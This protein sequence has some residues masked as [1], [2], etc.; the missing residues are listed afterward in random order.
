MEEQQQQ[1][2]LQSKELKIKN[3]TLAKAKE[4]IDQRAE[5]LEK[6]SK[7]KS[8]FLANMSH[9]LRTPLNSII[10]LSKLLTQ[11]QNQTLNE[12]D[13]ERSAVIKT[14][15]SGALPFIE[16]ELKE[17]VA[18]SKDNLKEITDEDVPGFPSIKWSSKFYEIEN[19]P[20]EVFA[21]VTVKW[22]EGGYE[23]QVTFPFLVTKYEPYVY[24]IGKI[25]P[26]KEYKR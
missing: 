1:L 15:I 4:E 2:T 7:Y 3:D 12:K 18:E 26:K 21:E 17:R 14:R 20:G 25:N 9:E 22:L 13:I 8:E 5:D 6:A 24:S 10:L 23:K 19:W 11:N 16:W